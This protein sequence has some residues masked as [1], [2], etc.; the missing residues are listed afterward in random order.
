MR[1]LISDDYFIKNEDWIFSFSEFN[2]RFYRK[3]H[4]EININC[5]NLKIP[6]IF[7]EAKY[8]PRGLQLSLKDIYILFDSLK[9]IY[10]DPT[11]RLN[12][13]GEEPL[14][15]AKGCEIICKYIK[16]LFVWPKPIIYLYTGYSLM[17]IQKNLYSLYQNL[18]VIYTNQ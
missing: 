5:M 10:E 14:S 4:I 12:I 13:R 2:H 6:A 16:E 3:N 17:D 11:I 8:Y 1:Y 7:E 15:Q 18:N 9:L